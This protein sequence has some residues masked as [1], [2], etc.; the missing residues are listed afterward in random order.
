M[1]KNGFKNHK[2]LMNFLERKRTSR[3]LRGANESDFFPR[4]VTLVGSYSKESEE[5]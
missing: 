3:D 2:V 4:R 5:S 1:K